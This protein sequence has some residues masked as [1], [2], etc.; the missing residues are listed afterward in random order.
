[1]KVAALQLGQILQNQQNR[2]KQ[3]QS[4]AEQVFLNNV[5]INPNYHISSESFQLLQDQLSKQTEPNLSRYG[6]YLNKPSS[7][8]DSDT[9]AKLDYVA[10]LMKGVYLSQLA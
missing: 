2:V 6:V 3:L 4:F 10:L 7:A 1:M 8:P 9:L 5:T